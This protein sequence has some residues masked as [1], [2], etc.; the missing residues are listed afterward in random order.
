MREEL[1]Y[2]NVAQLVE[3]PKYTAKETAIWTADQAA[4]FLETISDHPLYIAFLLLLT[5][6]MRRGEALGLRYSD[7]DFENGYLYIRQQIGRVGGSVKARD[8]KTI[9]SKRRLP[10]M[11]NVRT[12]LLNHAKRNGVMLPPFNPSSE[13]STQGTVITSKVGTPLQPRN[14][15]RSFDVLT[16]KAGLPRI[17][18]HA[19]RHTAATVL[20]DLNVPVKDAQL[21]LGHSNISTTLN[22]YQHGSHDTQRYAISAV[23]NCLF[24]R[25]EWRQRNFK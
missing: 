2:R 8:L 5:Y 20:K 10:L 6:G 23:E 4:L 25:R 21:I 7:I 1:V 12:A 3:R 19:L 24:K 15:G 11:A 18:I 14:L 16:K 17:K 22:I 9:N 13:L